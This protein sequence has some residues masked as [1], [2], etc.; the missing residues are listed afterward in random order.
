MYSNTK[1]WMQSNDV[2][3]MNYKIIISQ[4]LYFKILF[5]LMP[6]FNQIKSNIKCWNKFL[7]NIVFHLHN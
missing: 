5:L 7:F 1:I 2:G 6:Y 4:T 3:V